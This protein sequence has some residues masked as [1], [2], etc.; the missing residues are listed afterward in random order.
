MTP[1]AA[2]KAK[3]EGDSMRDE[4]FMHQ[5]LTRAQ[6]AL[7]NGEF[8][9]GCIIVA[10]TAVVASGASRGTTGQMANETDHAEMMAL[11]QLSESRNRLPAE[12]ADLT[13]FS[14]LEPC[15]MCFGAILLSGITKIVYAYED[16]MGGGTACDLHRLPP[17]YRNRGLRIVPHILRAESLRLLK[18]FFADP[19]NSYWRGSLLADY[20]LNQKI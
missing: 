4:D 18:T 7:E 15:L 16:V 11:R 10:G 14:T 1:Y 12:S 20:T 6:T 3:N 8:P 9:V 2:S 17:L 19:Q 5:A 13:L